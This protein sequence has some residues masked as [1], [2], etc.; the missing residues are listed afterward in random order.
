M[1]A[2]MQQFGWYAAVGIEMT[3]LHMHVAIYVSSI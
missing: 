3:T 1:H 2:C